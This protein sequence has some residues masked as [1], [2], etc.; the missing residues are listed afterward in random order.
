MILEKLIIK[1]KEVTMF[2]NILAF[3]DDENRNTSRKRKPYWHRF[4]PDIVFFSSLLILC[5]LHLVIPGLMRPLI[6]NPSDFMAGKWW[7]IFTYT[8]VHTS[9]YHLLLDAGAFFLLYTGL[10][11]RR[12]SIRLFYTVGCGV[13]SFGATLL[14]APEIRSLGLCGISGIAHGLMVVASL[15]MIAG[16]TYAKQGWLCLFIVGFKSLYEIIVGEM[17]FSFL[18]FGMCGIPL[19]ASHIGGVIGGIISFALIAWVKNESLS[20]NC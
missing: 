14:F 9:W 18:L 5:N 17:L 19:A 13:C 11:T 20:V 4:S 12:I 1:A 16:R 3:N 6:F 10:E 8:F 2:A 15:E 7:L